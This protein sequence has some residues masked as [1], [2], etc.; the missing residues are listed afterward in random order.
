M[1]ETGGVPIDSPGAKRMTALHIAA[2][3]GHYD[4][5]KY[6]LEK[7]AKINLKDKFKR[8]PIILATANGQL[9]VLSLLLMK[10]GS[11]NDAD[12]SNNYPVHYAAAY[13]FQSCLDLLKL[14]GADLNPQ[15][16]WNLTP[17]SVAMA[18]GHFGMVKK[19]LNN[20]ECDVNCTDVEGR[21]IISRAT[22]NL[23]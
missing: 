13:G 23:S 19:L 8:S 14:A 10:G 20:P 15:N 7:D 21:T 17:L 1:I 18:K 11:F 3:R 2:S 22:Q 12:S 5:V 16:S 4:L 9:K 6:L